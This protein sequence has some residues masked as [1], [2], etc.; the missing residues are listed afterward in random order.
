MEDTKLKNLLLIITVMTFF[1]EVSKA[2]EKCPTSDLV[3]RTI[4]DFISDH[5]KE[6]LDKINQNGIFSYKMLSLNDFFKFEPIETSDPKMCGYKFPG[7]SQEVLLLM[8]W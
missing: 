5:Q 2:E 4:Q 8:T 3:T 6:I 7:S 1:P